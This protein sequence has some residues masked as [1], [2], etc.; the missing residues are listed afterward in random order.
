MSDA[1]GKA[2]E[3]PLV[4]HVSWN[5]GL[6]PFSAF[7]DAKRSVPSSMPDSTPM[8]LGR[9][10]IVQATPLYRTTLDE[11]GP[12]PANQWL[13]KVGAFELALKVAERFDYTVQD[14]P[15]R[16][17]AIRGPRSSASTR[18]GRCGDDMSS[19]FMVF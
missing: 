3:Q 15:V 13:R 17:R 8:T 16:E 19:R 2:S 10:R 9:I 4:L 14:R 11:P 12:P 1:T 7:F 18:Q 5:A 6:L